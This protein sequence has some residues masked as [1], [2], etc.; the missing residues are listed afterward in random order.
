MQ[1]TIVLFL[2]SGVF[3]SINVILP[4]VS[5]C[6]Q[7]QKIISP[8]IHYIYLSRWNI[9]SNYIQQITCKVIFRLSGSWTPLT[10]AILLRTASSLVFRPVA[11]N[12]RG[13]SVSKLF[14]WKKKKKSQH[15][16]HFNL[17]AAFMVN[18]RR[19]SIIISF[20]CTFG[21]PI[22]YTDVYSQCYCGHCHLQ[23]C[24]TRSV[25]TP[26]LALKANNDNIR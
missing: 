16:N 3:R 9:F 22:I 21:C 13:D 20:Y 25:G 12:H 17:N 14:Q 11:S 6:K 8:Y 26:Y 24:L 18:W 23:Q 4:P 1:F 5:F 19:L 15:I 10:R 2:I 7:S